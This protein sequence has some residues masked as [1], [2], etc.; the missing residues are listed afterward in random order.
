MPAK[1]PSLDEIF[2]KRQF[3]VRSTAKGDA[4]TKI[5]KAPASWNPTT[6]SARFV[7][8]AQIVDRY[9]DIVV[10]K[11]G[12]LT[13]FNNNPIALWAHD[14][15]EF[16]IGMWQNINQVNGTPRRL[17]GDVGFAPEG[18][19]DDAD[20]VVSLVA[21]GMVR[22]CSIGFLPKAWESIKDKEDRWTGYQFNEWELLECSVCCIPANPAAIVKAAGIGNEG[23]ALQAI[24]L[25][26]DEWALTPDGLIVPRAEYER[27]YKQVKNQ[28]VTVHEV[29]SIPDED[30]AAPELTN[31]D[32]EAAVSRGITEGFT[33]A[34]EPD[35]FVAK[36]LQS[37][38]IKG[39]KPAAAK[40]DDGDDDEDPDG[41]DEV[42]KP[43][44]IEVDGETDAEF[45]ARTAA[46][47]KAVDDLA[48]EEEITALRQR[49]AELTA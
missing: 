8:T 4:L 23:A 43:K 17:E 45:E 49:A 11:G 30:A 31:L 29:R 6:R 35:G 39:A 15:S 44:D 32:I 41:D 7:M 18:T 36:L 42:T 21:A 47:Q 27:A 2:S 3:T 33:K 12:D 13:E 16:P 9:G 22:A 10:T 48:D 28:D 37:I 38:G 5:Y 24:E 14:A 34:L 1:V 26:L 40:D 20:T 19:T 25:V 46:A